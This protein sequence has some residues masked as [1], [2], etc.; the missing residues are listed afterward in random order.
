VIATTVAK[1]IPQPTEIARRITEIADSVDAQLDDENASRQS[2]AEDA[3]T[4][5]RELAALIGVPVT[6]PEAA[7]AR[8]GTQPGRRPTFHV[9][10]T[11]TVFAAGHVWT[12]P[13]GDVY[14]CLNLADSGLPYIV[15]SDPQHLDE[16]IR[17]ATELRH[18]MEAEIARSRPLREG[19][20]S[21]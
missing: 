16:L 2:I 19:V 14:G 13:D 21:E 18:K 15:F 4:R 7:P 20:M 5:L 11:A 1:D 12:D 17:V 8:P 10:C 6:A 3:V 9:D